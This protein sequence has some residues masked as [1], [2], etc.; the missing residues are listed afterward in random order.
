MFNTQSLKLY[1]SGKM[2]QWIN[3]LQIYGVEEIILLKQALSLFRL[4]RS[5][6]PRTIA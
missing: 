3:M 1:V 5:T 6:L 4:V 2:K